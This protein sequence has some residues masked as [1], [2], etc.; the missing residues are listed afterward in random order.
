MHIATPNCPCPS[1]ANMWGAL[2]LCEHVRVETSGTSMAY[3]TFCPGP[4]SQRHGTRLSRISTASRETGVAP[5]C[6]VQGLRLNVECRNYLNSAY[7]WLPTK[8]F[9]KATKR[10]AREP[11]EDVRGSS[12]ASVSV[13]ST[14]HLG[15]HHF[16]AQPV[17][18]L[19]GRP[20]WRRPPRPPTPCKPE[21]LRQ[22]LKK[23]D[24]QARHPTPQ[25]RSERG[26]S[27]SGLFDSCPEVAY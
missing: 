2:E 17:L 22:R 20:R 1:A 21:M 8:S 11:L 12:A 9:S 14:H 25:A 7:D 6:G 13:V 3:S 18:L 19:L 15:Q 23:H 4:L 16:W 24:C 5:K 27:R 26:V 10:V